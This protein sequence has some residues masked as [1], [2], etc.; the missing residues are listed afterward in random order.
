MFDWLYSYRFFS[1]IDKILFRKRFWLMLDIFLFTLKLI[2][3]FKTRKCPSFKII[4]YEKSPPV[5]KYHFVQSWYIVDIGWLYDFGGE[6]N[7][8]SAYIKWADSNLDY[9]YSNNI[10]W[11]CFWSIAALQNLKRKKVV[12]IFL[13][14]IVITTFEYCIIIFQHIHTTKT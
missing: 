4:S 13:W 10:N 6:V 11:L 3:T 2:H 7:I 14:F 8:Y 5:I 1:F 9:F 12:F